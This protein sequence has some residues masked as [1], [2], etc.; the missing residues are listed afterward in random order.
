METECSKMDKEAAMIR[1]L[2]LDGNKKYLWGPS[3]SQA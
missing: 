3:V 2:L 1:I